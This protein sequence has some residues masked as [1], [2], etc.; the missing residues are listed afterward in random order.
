[1]ADV[2]EDV[3]ARHALALEELGGVGA[4]LL[5][6]GRQQV[7]SLDLALARALHV[8]D[9][10]LQR[11]AESE[12]LLR[13]LLRATRELLETILVDEEEHV[14]WIESQLHI[15]KEAGFDNYLAQQ[16]HAK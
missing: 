5:Q 11:A 3:Q 7:P 1:M 10:R 6:Q 13:F 15:I 16:I 8:Q 2:V 9:G 4:V 12:R 14:D